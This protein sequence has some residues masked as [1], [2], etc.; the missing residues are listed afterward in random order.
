MSTVR[1]QIAAQ[2]RAD[3]GTFIVQGFPTGLP[4]N[5]AGKGPKKTYVQVYREN[6]APANNG[7]SLI[8][9][10]KVTVI[11]SKQ[12]TEEAETDLE[13]ALDLVLLS[14]E[15]LAGIVYTSVDRVVLQDKYNAYEIS[16]SCTSPNVYKNLVREERS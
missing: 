6:L 3:N 9:T 11:V 13:A 4:E 1:E 16:V 8:H 2:I 5:M 12:N 10:L 15:R 7:T 14:L